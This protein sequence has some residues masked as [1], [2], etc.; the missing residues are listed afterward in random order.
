MTREDDID[1]EY[2]IVDKPSKTENYEEIPS[3]TGE[4]IIEKIP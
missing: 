3:A 2:L 1:E 4:V